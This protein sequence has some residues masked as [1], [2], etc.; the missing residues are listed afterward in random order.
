[1]ALL[2]R[3]IGRPAFQRL[4]LA[5]DDH[6]PAV[7]LAIPYSGRNG[8]WASR[9]YV[10]R[11]ASPN[12]LGATQST[13]AQGASTARHLGRFFHCTWLLSGGFL[14]RLYLLSTWRRFGGHSQPPPRIGCC[15]VLWRFCARLYSMGRIESTCVA[16]CA[17]TIRSSRPSFAAAMC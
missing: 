2:L 8:C 3:C 7:A 1:M 14:R 11:G 15:L 16:V 17:L 9:I 4:R 10:H 13:S 5:S 6:S 12:Y